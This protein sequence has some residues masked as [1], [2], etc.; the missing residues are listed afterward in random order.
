M[1]T[2][3]SWATETWNPVV[4]CSRISAGCKNC[5]AAEA[6]KSARLQQFPQYQNVKDWDGTVE[7][8][9]S[10]LNKPLSWRSPQTIFV[11]SMSD[12]FHENVEDE[13]RDQIFAVMA[14]ATQH[15][16]QL[17]TKRPEQMK[18]YFQH[19]SRLTRVSY[20]IYEIQRKELERSGKQIKFDH[21]LTFP[22]PNV[23]LGTSV[24]NR[25][26]A[27]DR[28]PL[29]LM[30]PAT[31]RFLSCEPLLEAINIKD[32]L[33]ADN[34]EFGHPGIDW[35]IIGG[36]S[37]SNSRSCHIDWIR[38]IVTQCQATNTAVFVKQLGSD[39]ILDGN[40][41]RLKDRKGADMQ[42]FPEDL[43]IQDFPTQSKRESGTSR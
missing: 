39:A 23:W 40:R 2:K 24:E 33:S 17:L 34:E 13:W 16:F 5:Y 7:F 30:C 12:L 37:G 6:A 35:V 21:P 19:E 42:E 29:L 3:I 10:Q 4:G 20:Q 9:E 32:Y 18:E 15:T 38:S 11:C 43:Q 31:V 41:L 27:N 36:E 25:K 28:I 14:I 1:T 26:A 8:V 22:L